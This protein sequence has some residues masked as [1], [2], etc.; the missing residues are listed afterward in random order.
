MRITEFNELISRGNYVLQPMSRDNLRKAIE[1]PLEVA[2]I[3]WEKR[4][5]DRMLDDLNEVE[6]Q[7][8]LLQFVMMR[9]FD[10]WKSAGSSKRPVSIED[11]ESIGE[12]SESIA[13]Y[14]DDVYENL[15]D[16]TRE[17]CAK[18]F[19]TLTGKIQNNII[20]KQFAKVSELA[21][22]VQA[23]ETQILAI[24]KKFNQKGKS[25]IV[26]E[27]AYLSGDSM[28][29]ISHESLIRNWKR[30][31][32]WVDEE[33]ASIEMYK[34]L[35]E[36]SALFQ[37]GKTDLLLPP[38]LDAAIKWRDTNKPNSPWG[39]RH[40]PAF[41]RAM[42]YLSLSENEY[43]QK[44]ENESLRKIT[45]K[46]RI[47]ILSVLGGVAAVVVLV[48]ILVSNMSLD[49]SEIAYTSPQNELALNG[50]TGE[51]FAVAEE[52]GLSQEVVDNNEPVRPAENTTPIIEENISPRT[53]NQRI[54]PA[55]TERV[56]VTTTGQN[57]PATTP[58][59]TSNQSIRQETT[60]QEDLTVEPTVSQSQ[61][62]RQETTPTKPTQEEPKETTPVVTSVTDRMATLSATLSSRSLQ[63]TNDADLK[64]LLALQ[65][66]RFNSESNKKAFSASIYDA[67]YQSVREKAGAGFNVYSGHSNAVRTVDFIPGSTSFV[68]AGSDGTILRWNAGSGQKNYTQILAGRGIIEKIRIT[69]NGRWLIIAETRKG[70]LL[71][72]LSGGSSAPETL[73]GQELNVQTI[74]VAPDDATFFTAGV[75]NFIERYDINSRTSS[76]LTDTQSRVNSLAVSPNGE[77]LA[78]GTRDGAATIWRLN[79]NQESVVVHNQPGNSVQSV[80]FSPN[81]RYLACGTQN[82]NVYLIR[83]SDFERVATLSQ[84]NARVTGLDFSP[85]S[86]FLVSSGYDGKVILWNLND[87]SEDPVIFNDNGGFV[88]D[89]SFSGDGNYIVSGSAEESRLLARPASASLLADRICS[90]V[91]RNMTADE[92]NNY[93][94]RDI[95]YQKTCPNK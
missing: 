35:A 33:A 59:T 75:S 85:N 81:G 66:F 84:H 68:S 92:W 79:K 77:M 41:E 71:Q 49:D 46:K 19:K 55:R 95:Q 16:R 80:S 73:K 11:Y 1:K 89:V 22:I 26:T 53:E 76:K 54:E 67:L 50:S 78:G 10:Q 70:I 42:M 62:V 8:P 91:T 69:G 94:A 5:V 52:T 12:I 65:A 27:D 64:A 30:L 51:D 4:L 87:L 88:F 18:I 17:I 61:L 45:R 39:R 25:F 31:E 23:E 44:I 40:H 72:S 90:L 47:R 56:P 20:S 24:F 36:T 13:S 93:V 63:V 48:S 15:D 3:E 38:E 86:Q 28:V 57:V 34:K 32:D 83:T 6:D 37:S 60:R 2:G 29:S 82:G 14:A 7:L 21:K 58:V 9:I 74:A 43:F